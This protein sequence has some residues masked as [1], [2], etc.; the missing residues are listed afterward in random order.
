MPSVSA[1]WP[2]PAAGLGPAAPIARAAGVTVGTGRA[3][4]AK[5]R[6]SGG[7]LQLG[8]RTAGAMQ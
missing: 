8:G 1:P 7:L 4:Y 6:V 3:A 2:G 5:A